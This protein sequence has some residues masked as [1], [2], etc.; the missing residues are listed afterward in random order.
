MNDEVLSKLIELVETASPVIW[1]AALRR[2]YVVVIADLIWG[3]IFFG[4]AYAAYRYA[5]HMWDEWDDSF[6]QTVSVV[7]I[8][9]LVLFGALV[10]T[11]G[12]MWLGSPEYAA[13]KFLVK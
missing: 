10:I 13:I 9:L 6:P 3:A 8:A 5:R 1:A 12:L 2:V 4:F 7:A 11:S